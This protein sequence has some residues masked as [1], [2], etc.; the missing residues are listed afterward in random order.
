MS[1]MMVP[2]N[3]DDAMKMLEA[4]VSM[5]Q[6]ALVFLAGEDA[7]GLPAPAAADQLRALER[8]D[9]VG[10]ALRGRLL[11]VFDS[12]DGHVA[13]GQRTTRAWLIN[14]V[15]V[16]RGQAAEHLAVQALAR[17]HRVL[18]AALAEGW[19]ITK[20]E[21]LQL[22]K[23]TRPI[24]EE[25][26]AEAE[27]ILVAAAR[28]GVNLRGLA[29]ICAEIRAC[30]AER[31]PDDDNDKHLDR[32]VSLDT[33]F[34]GAGVVRG[35]LTPECAAM[36]QAVLDAL[37]APQGGGDL[38][39]RPQRYHDALAEAM[40]RLLASDLL[41][42]RAGQPVKALVHI[43]FAEL[44]DRDQDG[45]LQDKWIAEYRARWAAHR[46]ANSVST[47]DGGAWLEGDAARAVACDAMIIPVVTGDIDPGAVDELIALCVCYHQL[48][49]QD[50]PAEPAADPEDAPAPATTQDRIASQDAPDANVAIPAGLTG[51]AARRAEVTAAAADALAEMEHQIL[52]KILQV[53]SGPGGAASFLRR[54]L[55]GKP[56]AGSS[57]PLDVGQTDE[58]PLHLRR[59]VALR[60][61]HCQYPGGYFL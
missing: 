4:A 13:D 12:Q 6:C 34:E 14:S 44:R 41:P 45:I 37:S 3:M 56:L 25:Y 16:T 46:A 33:T 61:Q 38:R 9:A 8:T 49:T 47:G 7:A 53:V 28:A 11:A 17:S 1:T 23:W 15:Q 22:A 5:Q 30:T 57:L 21:A 31:D 20:S 36:V 24:P 60:D 52:G 35:D 43:Y 39:T 32:G 10:A 48:R 58:I 18:H 40:R 19:V 26:R 29:E 42:R 2:A 50:S 54:H 59:L 55:L 27:D 51:A